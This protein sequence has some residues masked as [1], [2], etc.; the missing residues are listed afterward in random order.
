[1]IACEIGVVPFLNVQPE[2]APGSLTTQLLV[3]ESGQSALELPNFTPRAM[4]GLIS[5]SN[6][7]VI[8]VLADP[9][10]Y[11]PDSSRGVPS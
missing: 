5:G 9:G 11:M 4:H 10:K 8:Q 6:A 2:M 3:P 1:M 7:A